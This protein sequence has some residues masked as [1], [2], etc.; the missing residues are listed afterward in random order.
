[1]ADA[2]PMVVHVSTPR[3]WRGGE[4]QVLYLVSEL[5][6]R[7]IPQLLVCTRGSE[8]ERVARLRG[9]PH[10]AFPRLGTF[11]P[12][13]ARALARACRRSG[14]NLVH[15]HDGDA[16]T[17]AVLARALFRVPA[18]LVVHR[19][20]DFPLRRSR[21]TRWKWNHP[22]VRR[23]VCVS[24][25]IAGVL[26]PDLA[27]PERLRVVHSG[28]DPARFPPGP[29]EGLLRREFA[30]PEVAR[31]VG[32]VAAL[33]GHKDYPTFVETAA[34]VLARGVE[35]RFFAIGEGEERSAIEAHVRR[36]GLE[37]KVLLAGFRPDVARILPELE[38]LLFPSSTEGLG[39]TVLDAFVCRVPVVATRAGGIPEMV[40]DGESGLL[41]EVGDAEGLAERV[42]RVLSDPALRA[43]LV[44][45]GLR[46]AGE[47]G[48]AR[49]AERILDVY[50]EVLA[51]GGGG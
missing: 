44:E 7:G 48:I 11:D 36:L 8:M 51:E 13:F 19:R 29:P 49:M 46:R 31:I 17:A 32:N 1:M 4:Q 39:T 24:Q 23:I 50:R 40:R 5:A 35:A 27:A 20:V 9:L 14:A 18:S 16:H 26:R 6:R 33:A 2:R 37:G 3:T 15:A 28:V 34:R 10:A 12:C 30:V 45:G 47:L 42:V 22:A 43:R 25:A 21:F 38:V 41:A